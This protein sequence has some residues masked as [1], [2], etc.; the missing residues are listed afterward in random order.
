[1]DTKL[2]LVW[3]GKDQKT[4]VEPRILVE[5][6][7]KSFSQQPEVSLIDNKCTFGN[8]LIHGDNLLALKALEQ[9]YAGKIK[10]VYIDPPYNTGTA[11][12]TYDDNLEHSTWLSLMLP[13]IREIWTLLDKDNGSLW[14]SIDDD[15]QAYLK[16]LCDEIFGRNNFVCTVIWE[17]K[18]A[19]QNDATWLS[20]SHDFILVYAKN[21]EKWRP[22]MLPRSEEMNARYK[23][24]DDDPRG[25][26][27]SDNLAVKTYSASCDYPITTPAGRVVNPPSGYC[28]RLSKES[29]TRYISENRIWF[30]SDGQ[31]VPRIKRFLTEVKQGSVCKTIWKREEVGDNQDAKREVRVFNDKIVFSTPKPE[32]LI[33]R[34]LT[35]ATNP[36]DWVLDSFLGSGTTTA[37]AQKMNRRWIGVEMTDV[38]YTHD[39]PRLD[40][41]I[42]GEDKGGIT[43]ETGYKGGGGYKFYE[44]APTL[45]LNDDFGQAIIN[46]EYNAAMLS[47]AVAKHEDYFYEPDSSVFW[48]QAH[49]GDKAFLYVTTKHI[50]SEYVESIHQQMKE[51]ETLLISCESFDELASNVSKAIVIKKIPQS[52]LKDCTYGVGNY[53]LNIV[54]PPEYEDGDND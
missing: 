7:T 48:K 37:V 47:A 14:I 31:G 3:I 28:W 27:Q 53:N 9:D 15:E 2:E 20:D 4:E 51:D 44:L 42:K 10:C 46:P 11:F 25:L 40:M 12:S 36:G 49:S 33:E 34:V 8:A 22:N 5:D 6:K 52:L 29:Y 35:L 38:A 19:P 30:G 18:Y 43:K 21:K 41:V 24:P 16:V 13:R 17:K 32:R 45:I 23:N 1:M 39:K 26:W 54:N 50:T